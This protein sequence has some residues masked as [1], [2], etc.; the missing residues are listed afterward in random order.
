MQG[1]FRILAFTH[2]STDLKWIGKLGIEKEQ[3]TARLESLKQ[4]CELDEVMLLSTCNR[5][6]VIFCSERKL[7]PAFFNEIM[8]ALYPWWST[9]DFN[10]AQEKAILFNGDEAVYHL[11]EVASSLDSLVVGEREII[12]QVRTA[13]EFCNENGL[14]GDSIRLLVRQTIETAKEVYTRTHIASRPVSVVSLAYRKLIDLKVSL[15]ARFLIIGAGQ[16]NSLMADFLN[17]HGF[18]NFTVFNRTFSTARKLADT[19]K[20]TAEPLSEIGNYKKGFDVILTC[21]AA[22]EH[23]ISPA[24]YTSLLNGESGRKIII[25]LSVPNDLDPAV[26]DLFDLHYIDVTSLQV[27]ANENLQARKKE[28]ESCRRII[29]EQMI[30]FSEIIR[31]RKVELAMRDIPGQVRSIRENAVMTVFA[32]EINSLDEQA[33]DVLEKV[34]AYVEKKYIS[35]PMVLAKEILLE[36]PVKK[37]VVKSSVKKV[38]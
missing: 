27:I 16:T 12:T 11:F 3:L 28:L 21:T 25:D 29:G 36:K 33:K 15:D 23:I 6:E 8:A 14:T 18:K 24:L 37:S 26:L 1:N 20:G 2:K 7:D 10:E 17:K 34:L 5:F 13:Y 30:R 32:N 35:V 22:A 38:E 9:A 31:E 19:L 4:C